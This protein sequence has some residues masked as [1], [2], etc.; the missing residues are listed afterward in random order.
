MDKDRISDE[1]LSAWLDGE[2]DATAAADVQAWLQRHPDE[3]ARVRRWAA[4]RDAL[5][6]HFAPVLNEPVP[7]RLSAVAWQPVTWPRWAQAAAVA[8][9]LA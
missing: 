6:A 5:R 8:G 1:R 4:D 7:A 9:L 2:L 3:A